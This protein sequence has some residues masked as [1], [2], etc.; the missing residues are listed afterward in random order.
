MAL[1]TSCRGGGWT[2]LTELAAQIQGIMEVARVTWWS[3]A[4]WQSISQTL[5]RQQ[6]LPETS[7]YDTTPRLCGTDSLRILVLGRRHIYTTLS[8]CADT[9]FLT[10]VVCMGVVLLKL[11]G[12]FN[13]LLASDMS[14]AGGANLTRRGLVIKK[15][16]ISSE[17]YP[18]WAD[19]LYGS[20][21]L[22]QYIE[23]YRIFC[24][25]N[26]RMSIVTAFVIFASFCLPALGS[27]PFLYSRT[28]R[29][30]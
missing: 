13:R 16:I 17:P 15:E 8:L 30:T 20:E 3:R 2:L 24:V 14:D 7:D 10:G 28:P 4:L 29:P 25:G 27:A 26:S 5:D 1:E 22:A 9:R 21:V 6:S 18:R 23:P 12:C 11:T 19:E